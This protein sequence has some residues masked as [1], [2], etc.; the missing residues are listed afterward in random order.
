MIL[1][2]VVALATVLIGFCY[3]VR[4][5]GNTYFEAERSQIE[6]FIARNP[7]ITIVQQQLGREGKLVGAA[8][9]ERLMRRFGFDRTAVPDNAVRYPQARLFEPSA[10][11]AMLVFVDEDGRAA[12]VVFA[13]K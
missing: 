4:W 12:E 2:S 6:A 9:R 11:L 1:I 3:S 10:E 13:K 8:E 7:P 5:A